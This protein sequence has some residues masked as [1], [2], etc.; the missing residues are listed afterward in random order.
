MF[1]E[2]GIQILPVLE[3][4]LSTVLYKK[5]LPGFRTSLCRW[6]DTTKRYYKVHSALMYFRKVCPATLYSL[7]E[8]TLHTVKEQN[9]HGTIAVQFLPGR[10]SDFQN[11]H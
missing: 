8:L 1:T 9:L 6:N 4:F 3:S 11:D 7:T 10:V 2:T 5:T